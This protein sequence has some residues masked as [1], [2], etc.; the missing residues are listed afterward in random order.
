M[1]N[2]ITLTNVATAVV[3]QVAAQ[4]LA[5]IVGNLVAA[6][7]VNRDFEPMLA[8]YGDVVN[9][10][11]PPTAKANNIAE[12]GTVQFQQNNL[13]NAQIILN[14]HY[15]A[16]FVITDIA[17][18][19]AT[20]DLL[21]LYMQPHVIALAEQIET[22]ILGTYGQ[23]NAVSSVGTANTIITEAVVDSAETG[24]FNAKVPQNAPKYLF[25]NGATYGALRQIPRFSEF[26]MTGPSGQPSPMITGQLALATGSSNGVAKGMT[27]IR[28]QYV[29]KVSTTTYNLC[30]HRDAI[31]LAMRRLPLPMP[32][33]G[34]VGTYMEYGG[35]SFRVIMSYAPGQLQNQ[36]T[37]D[38]LYGTG[39]LRNNF[40]IQ[41]LS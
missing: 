12:A 11:I 14:K 35:Y 17:K 39:P 41:V 32:G 37:I 13:G 30:F 28:S 26:Q 25:V 38:C 15:E 22:D 9:V 3:K 4:G 5:P 29:S 19:L 8:Q 24:L 27:I 36:V 31:A 16:S 33:T 21:T 34:A 40:A 23:F 6:S 1:A 18:A 2:E 10:P 20:P 7:V